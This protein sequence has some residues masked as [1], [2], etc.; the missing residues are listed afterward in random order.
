MLRLNPDVSLQVFVR[1]TAKTS[2]ESTNGVFYRKPTKINDR[3]LYK[4]LNCSDCSLL[5]RTRTMQSR[6]SEAYE[7]GTGA[8]LEFKEAV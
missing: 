3:L 1:P 6:I 7:T 5:R 4:I 2:A 8:L